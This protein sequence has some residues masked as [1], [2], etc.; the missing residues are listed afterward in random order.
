MFRIQWAWEFLEIVHAAVNDESEDE[1]RFADERLQ[2]LACD[3]PKSRCAR[4]PDRWERQ[5]CQDV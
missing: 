1:E 2:F 3:G 4:D 5:N